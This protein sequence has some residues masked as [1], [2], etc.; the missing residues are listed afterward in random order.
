MLASRGWTVARLLAAAVSVLALLTPP[1]QAQSRGT[2][3]GKVR[4]S[5]GAAIAN[6][7]IIVLAANVRLRSDSAGS[8]RLA[9]LPA[10]KHEIRFRRV[11]FGPQTVEATVAANRVDSVAI[12]L[13][14]VAVEL[15]GVTVESEARERL[16]SDFYH[17]KDQGHGH[18]VT[19]SQIEER[20]PA[21]LTDMVRLIPGVRIVQNRGISG[22]SLRF[23]RAFMSPGRDCPPQ[24][25]VDGVRVTQFNLDDLSPGD[26]EGIEL[27]SGPAGLP[28]QY[29]LK[30]GTTVCGIVLIWTRIP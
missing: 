21:L 18:Y 8:F 15:P 6:V 17:R 22:G 3:V 27:S 9:E 28:P 25:W 10:G 30:D 2:L 1:L 4:H 24:Y 13:Q 20:R 26:V 7:E 16:L 14:H 23:G 5:T 11:G 12:V 19:R 29:N